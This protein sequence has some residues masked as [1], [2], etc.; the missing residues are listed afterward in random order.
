MGGVF[1]RRNREHRDCRGVRGERYN[2]V[3]GLITEYRTRI[4]VPKGADNGK[5]YS[6]FQS[7]GRSE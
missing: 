4:R 1:S 3:F 5:G 2:K 7:Q 6:A